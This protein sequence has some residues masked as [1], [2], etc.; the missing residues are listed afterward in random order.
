MKIL[1]RSSSSTQNGRCANERKPRPYNLLLV[2][3]YK[4][5]FFAHR[6]AC[7]VNSLSNGVPIVEMV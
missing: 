1:S 6:V 7:H 3:E 5:V 4:P 2:H